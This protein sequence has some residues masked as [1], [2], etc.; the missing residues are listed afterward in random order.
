MSI[1]KKAIKQWPDKK[2]LEY[3][4]L[5]FPGDNVQWKLME[6][7]SLYGFI[8][9]GGSNFVQIDDDETRNIGIIEF[10]KRRSSGS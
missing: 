9:E 5:Q 10:L 2:A 7:E 8:T 4:E 1:R 3:L 6:G